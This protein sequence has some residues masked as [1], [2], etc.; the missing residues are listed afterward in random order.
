MTE[1]INFMARELERA[2]SAGLTRDEARLRAE[3]AV[4]TQFAGERP[5]ISALPKSRAVQ[6]ARNN[7]ISNREAATRTGLSIRRI[8]QLRKK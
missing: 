8:Q 3:T 6:I 7:L 4:R 5:Y 1:I 2:L